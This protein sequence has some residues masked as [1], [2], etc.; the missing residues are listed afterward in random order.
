M[1]PEET[2]VLASLFVGPVILCQ[3]LFLVTRIVKDDVRV[4]VDGVQVGS[5][6]QSRHLVKESH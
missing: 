3:P 6:D 2:Q 4:G 5:Q 1:V